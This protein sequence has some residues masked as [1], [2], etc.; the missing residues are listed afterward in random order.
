MRKELNL[1]VVTVIERIIDVLTAGRRDRQAR[2]ALHRDLC[3]HPDGEWQ[4]TLSDGDVLPPCTVV[5]RYRSSVVV[6][7]LKGMHPAERLVNA[8][9]GK[10]RRE[11][12]YRLQVRAEQTVLF[13]DITEWVKL[14]EVETAALTE[15]DVATTRPRLAGG[16]G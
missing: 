16:E 6:R 7:L 11:P 12:Y 5:T 13:R 14:G 9:Y 10:L 3:K 15:D 1:T 4:F 2:R 8:G